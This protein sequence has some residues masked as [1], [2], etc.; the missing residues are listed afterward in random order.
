MAHQSQMQFLSIPFK[1]VVRLG[2]SIINDRIGP[3]QE[4]YFCWFILYYSNLWNSETFFCIKATANLFNLDVN[5]LNPVDNDPSL[6]QNTKKRNNKDTVFITV[7]RQ[8]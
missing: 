6:K 4:K 2:V 7:G 8:S 3:T 5:R 1:Q